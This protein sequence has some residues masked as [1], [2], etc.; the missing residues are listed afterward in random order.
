MAPG[1]NNDSIVER[2]TEEEVREGDTTM[3]TRLSADRT[4]QD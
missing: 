4:P 1:L 2:A 3:V